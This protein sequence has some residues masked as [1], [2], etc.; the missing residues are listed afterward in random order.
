MQLCLRGYA[1]NKFEHKALALMNSYVANARAITTMQ[2]MLKH[3]YTFGKYNSNATL[4][5]VS[6]LL[7]PRIRLLL[8]PQHIKSCDCNLISFFVLYIKLS[9]QID[10]VNQNIRLSYQL[11]MNGNT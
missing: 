4:H 7:F 3:A 10:I 9:Y 11:Q 5:Y 6:I 8:W 1:E 2:I